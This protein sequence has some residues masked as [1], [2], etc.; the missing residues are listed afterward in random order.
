MTIDEIRDLLAEEV[1]ETEAYIDQMDAV[2]DGDQFPVD[3]LVTLS[4]L[5]G[6]LK[7]CSSEQV[8]AARA[9]VIAARKQAAEDEEVPF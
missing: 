1:S 4:L 3:D 9:A 8:A 5:K 6:L 2:T 7:A